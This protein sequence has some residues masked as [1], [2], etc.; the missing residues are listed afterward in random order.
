M[1][2]GKWKGARKAI[3]TQM[4]RVNAALATRKVTKSTDMDFGMTLV[5]GAILI[6]MIAVLSG[7]II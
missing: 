4:D 2:P 6:V 3:M 5:L 7:L 1:G